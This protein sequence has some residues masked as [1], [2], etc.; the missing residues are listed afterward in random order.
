MKR[1]LTLLMIATCLTSCSVFKNKQQNMEQQESQTVFGVEWKLKQIGNKVMKYDE[2]RETITLLMT[3]EPENVSGFSACNRYFGK[4]I[5][6]KGVLT[7]KDIASTAMM[8]PN[9]TMELERRY[10][11]QLEKVNNFHITEDG[12]LHLRK[13]EKVLL[14][15]VQ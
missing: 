5:Y 12:E 11:T 1:I 7:F 14:V 2:E 10:L 9:Q 6:R 4:F 8:C 15:F 3:S 13:D